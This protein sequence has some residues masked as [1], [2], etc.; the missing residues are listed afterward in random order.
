MKRP[1]QKTFRHWNYFVYL[2]KMTCMCRFTG[3]KK[4]KAQSTDIYHLHYEIVIYA[5]SQNEIC[6]ALLHRGCSHTLELFL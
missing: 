5:E 1:V 6:A 2:S 3:L 4:Q